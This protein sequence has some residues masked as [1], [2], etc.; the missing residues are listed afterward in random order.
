MRPRPET[1]TL[2]RRGAIIGGIE[3]LREDV[4]TGGDVE[5][6]EGGLEVLMRHASG[7]QREFT[8]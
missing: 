2:R 5:M 1:A 8:I 7:R 3:G 6:L 4:G